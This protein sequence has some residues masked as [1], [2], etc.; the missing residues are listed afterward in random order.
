MH[1]PRS[2]RNLILVGFMG[3]GKSSVGREIARRCQLRFL[4]TDSMIRKKCGKSISE[5]FAVDGEAA[6]REEEHQALL[7][8]RGAHQSVIATGGGIVL[9]SRNRSLL[10]SLG[11]V[12]WLTAEEEVIWERV[13]RKSTRPLLQTDDPRSTV[14]KLMA[15][16][17]PL[18]HET[19]HVTIDTSVLSHQEVATRVLLAVR[20]WANSRH[21][22]QD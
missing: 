4:D 17:N 13:S 10:R 15:V 3:S 8:L 21:E 16:R 14:T 20:A 22:N 9:A 7:S 5:I 18:Y 2:V 19:A 11:A 1:L 12:I 6:F